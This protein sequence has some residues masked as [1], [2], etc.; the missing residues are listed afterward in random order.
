[1][2]E[3]SPVLFDTRG[4]LGSVLPNVLNCRRNGPDR[5]S[6]CQTVPFVTGGGVEPCP[7]N[8]FIRSPEMK[9][10]F[11]L[12]ELIFIDNPLPSLCT[13]GINNFRAKSNKNYKAHFSTLQK[14]LANSELSRLRGVPQSSLVRGHIAQHGFWR[15]VG[16]RK[17]CVEF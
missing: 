4:C 12:W 9:E 15:T 1:M 3:V 2:C 13:G 8:S 6:C 10:S 14:P 16:T 11:L 17:I 7:I 5:P